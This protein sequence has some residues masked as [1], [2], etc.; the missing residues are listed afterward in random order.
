MQLSRLTSALNSAIGY[1]K[2]FFLGV[3]LWLI[4]LPTYALSS[5]A[6]LQTAFIYNFI[7]FIDWPAAESPVS[8]RLCVLDANKEMHE[9]LD[10]LAGKLANKKMIEVIYFNS[11]TVIA[12]AINSCQMVYQPERS[13]ITLPQSLPKGVVLVAN[14]PEQED[15]NVSISLLRNTEGRIEFSI[16]Q[17]AVL[18]SGVQM[19][20]Q[21]LKLATN[22]R[23]GKD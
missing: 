9:A 18:H 2:C 15:P 21:L 14:R 20:S 3:I 13:S 4:A 17:S 11:E 7:K 10:Q 23:G 1:L 19:S 8:L 12:T 6:S 5:E 22:A 16:N